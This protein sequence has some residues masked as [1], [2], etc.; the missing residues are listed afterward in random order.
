MLIGK[1]YR[2]DLVHMNCFN[3][4]SSLFV[5][6]IVRLFNRNTIAVFHSNMNSTRW[7]GFR[8]LYT[9]RKFIVINATTLIVK[10]LI[11]ITNVQRE[12]YKSVCMFKNLFNKKE[13]VINNFIQDDLI[14][15]TRNN[16]KSVGITFLGRFSPNKGS[17]DL[18]Y[19]AREM[20]DIP[21][22]VFGKVRRSVDIY[23]S[24]IKFYGEVDRST[25]LKQLESNILTLSMSYD[26]TF[27]YS[28]LETMAKGGVVITTNLPQICEWFIDQRNGL[29]F[30]PGDIAKAK[31]LIL[32]L[33]HNPVEVKKISRNNLIDV[34]AF[35]SSRL[36]PKYVDVYR[37][38]I[39]STII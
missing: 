23:P 28:I 25:V 15:K 21:F 20:S 38:I 33:K 39:N 2:A 6:Y 13:T 5:L 24:N 10:K 26:E 34:Q 7:D 11:F 17:E 16:T 18:A 12:E 32:Y 35:A 8:V 14:L 22:L 36:A 4:L 1:A 27:G 37:R 19:L 31:Q 9:I 30:D 3:G 29:M